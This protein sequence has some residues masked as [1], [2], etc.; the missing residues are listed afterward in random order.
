M[1][2][3][4]DPALERLMSLLDRAASR[5][6]EANLAAFP[7]EFTGLRYLC[8]GYA[9]LVFLFVKRQH[10]ERPCLTLRSYDVFQGVLMKREL[11]VA[12]RLLTPRATRQGARDLG[13]LW[14][15]A[16][17]LLEIVCRSLEFSQEEV[18]VVALA[19]HLL[20]EELKNLLG[21]ELI[22][23][24]IEDVTDRLTSVA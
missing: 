17:R 23:R 24:I 11:A 5:L 10:P 19:I 6:R 18:L 4:S 7:A 8:R 22:A 21:Y 14:D 20:G 15:D 2:I 1:L 13:E 9:A 12:R 3:S 16:D